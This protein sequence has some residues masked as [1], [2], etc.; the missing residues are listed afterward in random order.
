[1]FTVG[2]NGDHQPTMAAGQLLT[3]SADR[4]VSVAE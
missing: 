2:I 3:I 4:W 1:M